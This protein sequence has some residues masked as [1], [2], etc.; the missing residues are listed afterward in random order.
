MRDQGDTQLLDEA[1]AGNV[2]AMHQLLSRYHDRLCRVIAVRLDRRLA[3]RVDPEDV[4]QEAMIN[5][6]IR[7][8]TYL[9]HRPVAFYTWLKSLVIDQVIRV[10][11]QHLHAAK[12]SVRRESLHRERY[13]F[14]EVI[15]ASEQFQD[16]ESSPAQRAIEREQCTQIH[17]VLAQLSSEDRK[18]LWMRHARQ[19]SYRAIANQQAT[20][21]EAAKSRIR[22]AHS[23]VRRLF[24]LTPQ[25]IEKVVHPNGANMEPAMHYSG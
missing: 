8:P 25:E 13:R 9:K 12:R 19:M 5:A 22:R 15:P 24:R 18:L 23:R 4:L 20:S 10:H 7:L 17:F 16:H 14:R 6:A 11:R 1:H 2:L 3:A 21:E